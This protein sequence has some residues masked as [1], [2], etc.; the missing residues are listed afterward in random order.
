[1]TSRCG[2]LFYIY[3]YTKGYIIRWFYVMM[4]PRGGYVFDTHVYVYVY[5]YNDFMMMRCHK[6]MVMVT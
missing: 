1:M 5:V 2:M 6:D 3:I 4:K